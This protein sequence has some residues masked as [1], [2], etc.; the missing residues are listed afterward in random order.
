MDN[1]QEVSNIILYSTGCPVCKMLKMRLD[2]ENIQYLT[3]TDTDEMNKKGL[4]SAPWLEVD[5]Q[6]MNASDAIKW[7]ASTKKRGAEPKTVGACASCEVN[8]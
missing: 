1:Q 6:L 3:V 8:P 4:R 5:G 2:A 7:I